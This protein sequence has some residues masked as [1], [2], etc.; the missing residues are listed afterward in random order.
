MMITH[1]NIRDP[2]I[3]V[4]EGKYYLYGTRSETTWGL[5][6]GF[7]CYVS[8]DL[9][10]WEK[11][12]YIFRNDG[13]FW[14]DRSYW[15]PECYERDGS[16]YLVASFRSEER[17][18]G[19]QIL[20]ADCPEGPFVPY[21]D[22]PVTPDD[23]PCLDGTVFYED[24][25][26]WL[27]YSRSFEKDPHGVMCA[28]RLTQDWNAA[29]GA[30]VALFSAEDAPW[31]VPFPF[32][33]EEFGR[34]DNMYLSDGPALHCME[35]GSLLMLWSSFGAKGYTVGMSRSAS[36]RLFGPWEHLSEPIFDG[37]GGHGMLF[38][39][40]EGKLIYTLHSPNTK[41]EEKP[42]FVPVKEA[43]GCLVIE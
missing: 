35:D 34:D 31:A 11:I 40:L 22:G 30:P 25:S 3:L 17:T 7:D 2:F 18:L 27:V 26:P 5:A 38:R 1:P 41:G 16:F 14:A 28:L 13:T 32:A 4:H 21:S 10:E 36:G 9:K 6:D 19:I 24:G 8:T 42:I 15:A 33:R 37:D 29:D 43:N 39:T 12:P 20:K 23:I